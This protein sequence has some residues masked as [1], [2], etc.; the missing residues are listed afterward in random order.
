MDALGV[1]LEAVGSK[2]GAVDIKMKMRMSAL[3]QVCVCVVRV[4]V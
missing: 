1:H 2:K 4:C 3:G